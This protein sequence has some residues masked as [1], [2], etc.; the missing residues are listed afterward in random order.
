M[1]A[2]LFQEDNYLVMKSIR[3]IQAGQEIFNDYGPL[4]RSDLLRMYGY[5]TAHYAQYDVVEFSYDLLEE[6]AG[7]KHGANMAWQ[8][9]KEAL[10]ELGLIDDGYAIARPQPGH[11]LEDIIPAPLHMLLRA[12]CAKDETTKMPKNAPKDAV[13]IEETALLSAVLTKKLSEYSTSIEEDEAI[14]TRLASESESQVARPRYRM[15]VEVRK[16]EKE[17]LQ[18]AIHL[19]QDHIAHQTTELAKTASK[20]RKHEDRPTGSKKVAR[21]EKGR[22]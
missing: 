14:L 5:V 22:H 3:P 11:K 16:G 4:P 10:D 12:L 7:K 8:K 18:Q 1:Q 15:A 9:R 20:R 13:T 2:R 17:V 19:C 6:V 21:T